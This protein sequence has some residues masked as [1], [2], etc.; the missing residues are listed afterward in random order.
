MTN[1]R[2][3]ELLAMCGRFFEQELAFNQDLYVIAKWAFMLAI[4]LAVLHALVALYTSATAPSG[5]DPEIR[6][7]G[8]VPSPE[9]VKAITE[10]IAG[11]A[12][13]P[14]W[15]FLFVA[16]LLLIWVS[17]VEVPRVCEAPFAET[18]EENEDEDAAVEAA[19][20]TKAS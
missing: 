16:G 15:F 4:G 5:R 18:L 11:L 12:K 6:G 19:A 13:A 1:Q 3:A 17:T 14:V 7:K 2:T 10:F 8:A 9:L 20:A